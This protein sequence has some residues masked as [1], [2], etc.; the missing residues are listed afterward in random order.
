MA[1]GAWAG[2]LRAG[3]RE[4][5][6]AKGPALVRLGAT[7]PVSGRRADPASYRGDVVLDDRG[8]GAGGPWG[9]WG[10][11]PSLQDPQGQASSGV[12]TPRGHKVAGGRGSSA[13]VCLQPP[14]STHPASR[15]WAPRATPGK[16]LMCTKLGG[17]FR[18]AEGPEEVHPQDAPSPAPLL[19]QPRTRVLRWGPQDVSCP[20][21]LPGFP[22]QDA[23]RLRLCFPVCLQFQPRVYADHAEGLAPGKDPAGLPQDTGP[24][25]LL[26]GR[27]LHHLLHP[28]WDPVQQSSA[29][30][31]ALRWTG[32]AWGSG[33]RVQAGVETGAD[34]CHGCRA[35]RGRQAP[36]CGFPM[37]AAGFAPGQEEAAG[38]PGQQPLPSGPGHPAPGLLDSDGTVDTHHRGGL[39]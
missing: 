35:Q 4:A 20:W 25:G 6:R 32:K 1:A 17:S 39:A 9:T 37:H 23:G 31:G 21:P 12:T 15:S 13:Q 30:G 10:C 3:A 26:S 19:A 7:A 16:R 11:R 22:Q 24:K 33:S 38:R 2:V 8:W 5:A 29:L 27:A 34:D 14:D 36:L 18:A 28:P